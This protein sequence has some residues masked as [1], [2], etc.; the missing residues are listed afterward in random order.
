MTQEHP[1]IRSA[2]DYAEIFARA[3]AQARTDSTT[4]HRSPQH[5]PQ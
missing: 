1:L 2:D 4:T 3:A 5:D